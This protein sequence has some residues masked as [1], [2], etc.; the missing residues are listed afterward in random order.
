MTLKEKSVGKLERKV[1]L[2]T[3]RNSGIGVAA[4]REFVNEGAYVFITGRLI[5]SWR[6]RSRRLEEM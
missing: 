1:A 2:V 5:R 3:G 4:A 6:R